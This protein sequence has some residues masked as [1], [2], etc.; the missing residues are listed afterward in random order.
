MLASTDIRRLGA[1]HPCRSVSL[2]HQIDETMAISYPGFQYLHRFRHVAADTRK[3]IFYADAFLSHSVNMNLQV[4][5]TQYNN[6]QC[7]A[8]NDEG[9][10]KEPCYLSGEKR[11]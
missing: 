6:Y 5:E 2:L 4:F 9:G 7:A 3:F 8:A 11:I 1:I 10:S